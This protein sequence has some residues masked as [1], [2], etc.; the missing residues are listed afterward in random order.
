MYMYDA[1][2]HKTPYIFIELFPILL[3]SG[4]YFFFI[5]LLNMTPASTKI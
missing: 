3:V 5:I 1:Y 2:C 4:I